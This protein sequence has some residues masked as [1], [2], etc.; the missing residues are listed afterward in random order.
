[1]CSF[2]VINW[3]QWIQI[4]GS[5]VASNF[6]G[7]TEVWLFWCRY[8]KASAKY[9]QTLLGRTVFASDPILNQKMQL[10]G[11]VLNLKGHKVSESGVEIFGPGDIEGHIVSISEYLS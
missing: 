6:K 1:M 8:E 5:F 2:D 11:K 9:R 10:A 3:L 7:I 4:D